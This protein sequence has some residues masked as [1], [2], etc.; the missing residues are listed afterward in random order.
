MSMFCMA[1]RGKASRTIALYFF[2]IIAAY[3]PQLL[4][5][6][7]PFK[8]S[9]NITILDI[10]LTWV[11]VILGVIFAIICIFIIYTAINQTYQQYGKAV[12]TI[13]ILAVCIW[14][15]YFLAME[16]ASVKITFIPR[17]IPSLLS[18]AVGVIV[19][20]IITCFHISCYIRPQDF[21]HV[22]TQDH[23]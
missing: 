11:A 8:S 2:G 6:V 21:R 5:Y 20:F 4:N 1:I 13:I 16:D 10:D 14:G 22:F 12:F 7:E 19:S 23:V 18:T 15:M 9:S 3:L 17:M